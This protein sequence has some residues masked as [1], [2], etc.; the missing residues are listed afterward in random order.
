VGPDEAAPDQGKVSFQ[1]PLGQALLKRR[2]GDT[3]T[4]RRPRGEM[5]L[6]IVAISYDI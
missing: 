5:D 4:V 3:V 6:L 1:S 2:V